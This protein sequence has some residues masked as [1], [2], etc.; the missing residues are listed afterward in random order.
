[1][2]YGLNADALS[3]PRCLKKFAHVVGVMVQDVIGG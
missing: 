2:L 1:M 3:L